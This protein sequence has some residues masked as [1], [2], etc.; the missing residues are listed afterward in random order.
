M[1]IYARGNNGTHE[2]FRMKTS[3]VTP[4]FYCFNITL[5]LRTNVRKKTKIIVRK[6]ICTLCKLSF[7]QVYKKS[8]PQ[9]F[10]K[11]VVHFP[12]QMPKAMVKKKLGVMGLIF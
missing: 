10:F 1:R 7:F 6:E 11:I 9:I 2:G 3:P 4:S 8:T 5:S 12:F